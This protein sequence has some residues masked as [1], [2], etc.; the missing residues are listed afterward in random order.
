MPTVMLCYVIAFYQIKGRN[1][2]Q[3]WKNDTKQVQTIFIINLINV[4]R[5]QVGD[6]VIF[7]LEPRSSFFKVFSL[8]SSDQKPA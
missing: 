6:V 2:A 3:R 4:C 7:L 5:L 1:K 8:I